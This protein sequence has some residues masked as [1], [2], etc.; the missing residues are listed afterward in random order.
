MSSATS[1]RM[2]LFPGLHKPSPRLSHSLGCKGNF[3]FAHA[4]KWFSVLVQR[5]Y[6]PI[7]DSFDSGLVQV[8]VAARRLHLGAVDLSVG[9][10]SERNHGRSADPPAELLLRIYRGRVGWRRDALAILIVPGW[11]D[12]PV[13]PCSQCRRGRIACLPRW[14]GIADDDGQRFLSGLPDAD[15][16]AL[17]QISGH[18]GLEL[19]RGSVR[20]HFALS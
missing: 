12:L 7:K 6:F 1:A 14:I 16:G 10:E 17:E 20:S 9:V 5:G 19:P 8:L 3:R 11:T 4:G 18:P 15:G 13:L 2:P